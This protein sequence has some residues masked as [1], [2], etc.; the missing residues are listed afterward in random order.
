[1]AVF[2]LNRDILMTFFKNRKKEMRVKMNGFLIFVNT[3]PGI[4][5]LVTVCVSILLIL[6][7]VLLKTL[8]KAGKTLNLKIFGKHKGGEENK[9][10][11]STNSLPH[12]K[13]SKEQFEQ[14]VHNIK[15]HRFFSNTLV[16]NEYG[17]DWKLYDALLQEKF[18]VED[19][20]IISFKKTIANKFLSNC[21][22]KYLEDTVKEWLEEVLEQY[23]D[24]KEETN[25]YQ[26]PPTMCSIIDRIQRFTK[27]TSDLASKVQIPF[28]KKVITG[29][30]P[31][32]VKCFCTIVNQN[33]GV[34]YT[35]ISS[36]VYTGSM[37]WY[38]KINEILDM[39]ELI[40]SYVKTG[41][42]STLVV[43]NGQIER[44]VENLSKTE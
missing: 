42:D 15:Y 36:I 41:V 10:E 24:A 12:L 6:V 37:T 11:D 40:M 27:Q 14:I 13:T 19:E 21:L 23:K 35:T 33:F 22:F 9:D 5:L 17:F 44:Y 16:E 39:M 8:S 30:P 7:L 43:M 2:F 28:G 38:D 20:R 4:I 25:A 34:V 31:E 1:M 3:I 26:V 18:K 32:F 29:I